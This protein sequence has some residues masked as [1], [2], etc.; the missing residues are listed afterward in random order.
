MARR[1]LV[2]VGDEIQRVISDLLQREL[3]DP[4]LGFVTVTRVEMSPDLKL[5]RVFVSVLGSDE[6]H[7]KS[8]EALQHA[9]GF[10]RKSLA[11]RLNLRYTPDL[12]F[13]DDRSMERAEEVFRILREIEDSGSDT[14]GDTGKEENA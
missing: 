6:E 14:T 5:G 9:K 1:R 12:V 10:I 8:I 2:Q 3:Q 13:K 4:R 11:E 7:K